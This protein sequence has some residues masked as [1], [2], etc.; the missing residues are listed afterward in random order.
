MSEPADKARIPLPVAAVREPAAPPS[1]KLLLDAALGVA[2]RHAL[3][4]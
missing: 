2:D 3:A 1:D 4:V